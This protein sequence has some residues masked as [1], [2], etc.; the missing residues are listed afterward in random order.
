M[1]QRFECNR[2]TDRLTITKAAPPPADAVPSSKLETDLFVNSNRLKPESLVKRNAALIGEGN[3]SK[4]RME[5]LPLK[6]L[7][8]GA[9]ERP[10][11]AA[12]PNLLANIDSDVDGPS[13]GDPLTVSSSI[14]V[15]EDFLLCNA[16][17]PWKPGQRASN[18]VFDLRYRGRFNLEGNRRS[19][20]NRRIDR[21]DIACVVDL[22]GPYHSI[23]RV[24][25]A[26]PLFRPLIAQTS[27]PRC[28]PGRYRH[29]L[30]RQSQRL[31]A[32]AA[33][34][35]VSWATMKATTPAGDIPAKL[36][37]SDRAMVTAGF[38]NDVDE[39]NQYAAVM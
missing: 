10:P 14:G 35:P 37:E 32:T 20:H 11:D 21:Q 27:S 2:F 29:A 13:V 38:A 26:A 16:D 3:P 8:Q 18:P 30:L 19:G 17:K 12:S 25:M 23:R 34:I 33:S 24:H 36:S 7:E 9:V 15:T 31:S 6:Y 1:P 4:R 22:G 5:S 39:V 28:L